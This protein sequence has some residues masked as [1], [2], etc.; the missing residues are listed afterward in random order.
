MRDNVGG[1]D[2]VRGTLVPGLTEQSQMGYGSIH[3]PC[4][5]HKLFMNSLTYSFRADYIPIQRRSV[6]ERTCFTFGL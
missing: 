3:E 6:S 4:G 5:D 2:D 1:R